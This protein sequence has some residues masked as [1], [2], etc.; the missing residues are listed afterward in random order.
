MKY[1]FVVFGN[2]RDYFKIMFKDAVE[3][4]IAEYIS[5][6]I[7][8]SENNSFIKFLFRLHNNKYLNWKFQMPF[9]KV[10]FPLFYKKSHTKPICFIFM[11]GWL[12]KENIIFF[13]LLKS[14]Y[15]DCKIGAYLEDLIISRPLFD[16]SILNYFDFCISYDPDDA[17]KLGIYYHP[18]FLSKLVSSESEERIEND[19]NFIGVA[20]DRLKMINQA[21]SFFTDNMLSC[22]FIVSRK[23][24]K[25]RAEDGIICVNQDISYTEYISH[26]LKS[27]CILEL[28]HH[29]AKGYTLRTWEALLYGKVLITNNQN[30]RNLPYYNK[31]QFIIFDKITDI[32]IE[33]I[34]KSINKVYNFDSNLISPIRFFEFIENNIL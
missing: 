18:T 16:K 29:S 21:H 23:S 7:K 22:D 19:I 31:D 13:K 20:K 9:K 1:D 5:D 10:W 25:E 15:P 30:V 2:P 3:R 17:Q 6:P 28:M 34:K 33:Q 27:K 4:N 11:M 12:R 26:V 32:S 14:S 24:S 8:E